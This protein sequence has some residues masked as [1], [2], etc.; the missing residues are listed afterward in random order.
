MVENIDF[1]ISSIILILFF[2]EIP[3]SSG[4]YKSEDGL[5]GAQQ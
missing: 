3:G 5:F 1:Q 2:L 4:K